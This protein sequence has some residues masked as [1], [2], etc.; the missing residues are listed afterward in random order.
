MIINRDLALMEIEQLLLR[1]QSQEF[2]CF[3]YSARALHAI[4]LGDKETSA[5]A[6]AALKD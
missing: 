4:V 3:V 5:A 6:Y 1:Q 2:G